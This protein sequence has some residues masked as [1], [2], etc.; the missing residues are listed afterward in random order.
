MELWTHDA[1]DQLNARGEK[2]R[3]EITS[4]FK[5]A[6]VPWQVT[7]AGSLF[8]IHPHNRDIH[9]YRDSYL[10][11]MDRNKM[12]QLQHHLINEGIYLS[13]NGLGCLS[14][15]MTQSELDQFSEA[16]LTSLR[17]MREFL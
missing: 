9:N 11:L 1:I 4:V 5:T 17:K 7:G 6:S 3:N 14:T 8:R 10:N 12:I 13:A 2:L 15:A 16:L